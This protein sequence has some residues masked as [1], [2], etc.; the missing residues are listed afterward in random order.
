MTRYRAWGRESL[1]VND[2]LLKV[3]LGVGAYGAE[4]GRLGANVQVA[5]V[6]A[7]PHL[8]ALAGKDLALLNALGKL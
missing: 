1:V 2:L 8:N 5:A 6:E 4:L 7:L 3:G